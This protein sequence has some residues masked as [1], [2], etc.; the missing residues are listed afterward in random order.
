[1]RKD[2]TKKFLMRENRF[3]GLM[4]SKEIRNFLQVRKQLT[5]ESLDIAFGRLTYDTIRFINILASKCTSKDTSNSPC[6]IS[7]DKI[8]I[9]TKKG[10][11]EFNMVYCEDGSFTMGHIEQKDNQPRLEIIERPFWLGETEV[12]QELYKFVMDKN[13]SQSTIAQSALFSWQSNPRSQHPVD[14]VTWYDA[15]RFCNKLSKLKGLQECYTKKSNDDW[16]CDFTKNGFRLPREKEWEYAA[17][18]GTNNRWS[19]TNDPNK[20]GEYAWGTRGGTQPVKMKKPNE[21]G[22]YDMSGNVWEWCDSDDGPSH[23]PFYRGGGGSHYEQ[24]ILLNGSDRYEALP[25]TSL[26]ALG[27][28]ICRTI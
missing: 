3:K 5:M 14:N 19:G 10:E 8:G 25:K 7:S 20:L 1:M 22:F 4:I 2:T 12:T 16:G 17:K 6:F 15:I 23:F 24:W 9:K 13:P 28:R 26:Y 27:F 18:A 11:I 21:W